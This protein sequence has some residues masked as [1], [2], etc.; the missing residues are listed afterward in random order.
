VGDRGR[1][2]D[3]GEFKEHR[4]EERNDVEVALVER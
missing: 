2:L 1:Y 3:M 4:S